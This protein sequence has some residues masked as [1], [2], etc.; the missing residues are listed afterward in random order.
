MFARSILPGKHGLKSTYFLHERRCKHTVKGVVF[1]MGGVILPSPLP[2]IQK[3]EKD[4]G[5][6]LGTIQDMVVK[7]YSDDKGPWA[8]LEKGEVTI[9]EFQENLKLPSIVS[10]LFAGFLD[11]IHTKYADPLPE[12]IDLIKCLRAE[13]ILVGLL[14]NNWFLDK[15]TTFLPLDRSLFDQ[16]VES[17][18]VNCRK[19]GEEI[20]KLTLEKLGI[21]A[22]E[23]LFIDDMGKN[24]ETAKSLGWQGIEFKTSTQT[25][26]DLEKILGVPLQGYVP[27]SV[28]VKEKLKFDTNSLTEYLKE[29][30]NMKTDGGMI[31]RQFEHGQSNPTYYIKCNEAEFV[32]RKKPP[33]KLLPSA[34]AVE[35]E[36][37]VMKAMHENGVPV[38]KPIVLCEDESVIGTP[39]YIM[40]Y[41]KGRIFKDPSLPGMSN[42]TR[43]EIYHK[44]N[45]VLAKIHQVD[46]K[47]AALEDYGKHGNYVKR[48]TET[49][50]KQY[51]A[52]KTHE[53]KTMDALISWL[54]QNVPE[55][56]QTT[57]VH[58]DFR[59]DNLVF[60]ENEAK[61]LAVLD[62]ELST[63]GDP[64]TDLALNC[65]PYYLSPK[66]PVLKGLSTVDV[67]SLGIPTCEEYMQEY[68]ERRKIQWIENWNVYMAFI[69]FRVA[70]ILQGVYKR[71]LKGQESSSDAQKVGLLAEKMAEAGWSF[72]QA[73]P[74]GTSGP[75]N[76]RSFSTTASSRSEGLM[77]FSATALPDHVQKLLAKLQEF[78]KENIYPNQSVFEEHQKSEDCWKPHPLIETLKSEA[79]AAGLWNLFIPVECDPE[80]VYGAGLTNVEYAFLCEEMGKSIYA[81]E[82]FNC[83]APDT[84]NMEVLIK[85]GSHE[86]KKEWLRPLLDGRI[87]SCFAMTE[88]NVASSDATNIQARIEEDGD[89]YVING[90]KW[91]TSGALDPRCE[92]AIFMGKTDPSAAKHKQQSMVLVPFK[93]PGVKIIRPLSMFGY[94]DPPCGH[95]EVEFKD[96]RVPK[97]NMI[98]GPGRGFEI[99][100]GRL[101]PGR[102]HHCMRMIGC[103]ERSLELMINR[104]KSRIT[105]GK[106]LIEQ[107]KIIE[108]IAKSRMEIEQARLLTVKAAQLMDTVGNK[109]ASSEIAM[110]KVVAPAMAQN[111]TDRAIQAFGGAGV[112]SDFPLAHFWAM[113]RILRLADGPDEVHRRAV[114][115]MEIKRHDVKG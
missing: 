25:I 23:A 62:W 32:L 101:G 63:L 13:G 79:Q 72:T 1:D 44:M 21:D 65:L 22:A 108:D 29:A 115:R 52:S 93:T 88:P 114:A 56:D 81:P 91:W 80:N 10:K 68:C 7:K 107:G 49:W 14:T 48:Q 73:R 39:F 60:D 6:P 103:A 51:E 19:P 67:G 70:A 109:A 84:G 97:S 2:A 90:R 95:G 18:R 100:Q 43:K 85:Y 24:V 87:R 104:V 76:K 64:V 111:V 54:R 61:V 8:S 16:V 110:I 55:T 58:G 113:S 75:Q 35:R 45:E 86:Q 46:I 3:A 27:G 15:K 42:E 66:F 98:L 17:A 28:A 77:P 94:L 74:Q 53:I 47:K 11:N 30:L 83:S 71:S 5:V 59:I 96:V 9:K 89:S 34:H 69:L 31:I 33:G 102:I 50:A 92:L 36:Y 20:Y 78:M 57:V 105:F 106:P 99:A 41:V 38:P 4:F 26:E 112:S 40:E 37:R 12:M 82:I